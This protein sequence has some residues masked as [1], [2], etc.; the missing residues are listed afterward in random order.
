[1]LKYRSRQ[2]QAIENKKNY[3]VGQSIEYFTS[4]DFKWENTIFKI[5]N[6]LLFFPISTSGFIKSSPPPD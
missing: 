2:N 4:Q 1:M 3:S 5:Y 6:V